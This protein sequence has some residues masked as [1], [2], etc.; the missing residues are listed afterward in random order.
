LNYWRFWIK[1]P[2]FLQDFK[3]KEINTPFGIPSS[4]LITGKINGIEL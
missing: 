1:N 4:P 3:V 2:E